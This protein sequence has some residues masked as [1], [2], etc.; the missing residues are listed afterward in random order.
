LWPGRYDGDVL[1]GR[2]TASIAVHITEPTVKLYALFLGVNEYKD[3]E[4]KPLTG[5][6]NDAINLYSRFRDGVGLGARAVRLPAKASCQQ[7]VEAFDDIGQQLRAGDRFLFYFAGHGHELTNSA[8]G[9]QLLLLHGA[10]RRLYE[11]GYLQGE[12]LTLNVLEE[13]TKPWPRGVTSLFVLDACR[14]AIDPAA[15]RGGGTAT[16]GTGDA[17][18]RLVA[19]GPGKDDGRIVVL[20][21]CSAGEEA[22]EVEGVGGRFCEA[23]EREIDEHIRAG[24]PMFINQ[25]TTQAFATRIEA[26]Q[27]QA[28]DRRLQTPWLMPPHAQF[29]LF[30]PAAAK[31]PTAAQLRSDTPTPPA[32]KVAQRAANLQRE[33]DALWREA[34]A[35]DTDAAYV[36][37]LKDS[38]LKTHEAEANRRREALRQHREAQAAAAAT[39]EAKRKREAEA[40]AQAK[41]WVLWEAAKQGD[42]EASYAKYLE[43][44]ALKHHE[45]EARRR[46]GELR[47]ARMAAEEAARR[48]REA[49]EAKAR[50]AA[51]YAPLAVFRDRLRKA[52]GE[53]PEMV[54]RIAAEGPQQ[55]I[56]IAKAFAL[57]KWAAGGAR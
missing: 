22:F 7:V 47:Q 4:I 10:K 56:T 3:R 21:A 54:V 1:P 14:S 41:E 49:E 19:R 17:I 5:A 55:T 30:A 13:I 20:S 24:K 46:L 12:L 29:E 48:Q 6:E 8:N 25:A 38:E 31:P 2:I 37:Y 44:T 57:G 15:A 39:A 26:W 43:S 53:G 11:A 42:S 32:P 52:G 27:R 18:G 9:D 35:V 51:R 50:Q 36:I 34:R 33:E 23:I 40:A 45:A 16:F 28:G